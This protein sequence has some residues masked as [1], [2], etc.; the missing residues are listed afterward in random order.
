MQCTT[1]SMCFTPHR[2]L[3]MRLTTRDKSCCF[4]SHVHVFATDAVHESDQRGLRTE[5]SYPVPDSPSQ[6][7]DLMSIRGMHGRDHDFQGRTQIVRQRRKGKR[8]YGITTAMPHRHVY[9]HYTVSFV[10][11]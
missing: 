11:P 6:L 8:A 1:L 3:D 2:H 4:L 5:A 7:H 10:R 9:L